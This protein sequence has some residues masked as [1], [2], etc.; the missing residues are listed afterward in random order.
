MNTEIKQL[1]DVLMGRDAYG[2]IKKIH[3]T[4]KKH[5]VLA[6]S[7]GLEDQVLTDM[8]LKIN[9]EARIIVL[10]TG[11]L[12]PETYDVMEKTEKK[13]NMTFEIYYPSSNMIELM[14]QKKG[15]NLFYNSIEN[16][17]ECC[18]IR[19]VLPLKRALSTANAWI[20]GIRHSQS[21]A[22]MHTPLV[23]WDTGNNC[24]KVNPLI[25]WSETDVK[26]Y[27]KENDVPYNELHDKG[28]PSIGCA[29]C[30]RA[31]PEGMDSRSGRWWWEHEDQ[32][33]CGLH[34]VDGKLVRKKKK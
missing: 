26:H 27:I 4:Y 17:K 16:R 20:T 13:Y 6:S 2:C 23:E 11:R 12:H 21:A 1:E 3:D 34:V 8:F 10:D 22:R 28:F 15:I 30:T 29:P 7:L 25:D 18:H 24:V 5:L 33:E 32:K 31:V 19:K 9:P 14:V